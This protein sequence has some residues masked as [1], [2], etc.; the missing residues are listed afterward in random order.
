M[1]LLVTVSVVLVAVVMEIVGGKCG[2]GLDN[3]GVATDADIVT[4][5]PVSPHSRSV[6]AVTVFK[7]SRTGD[8]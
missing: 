5:I 3:G 2:S 6:S 1:W 8:L 7:V 4:F